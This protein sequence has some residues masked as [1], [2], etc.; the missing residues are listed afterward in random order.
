M[1]DWLLLTL[2]VLE[3]VGLIALFAISRRNRRRREAGKPRPPRPVRI[4][5]AILLLS[6]V[7]GFPVLTVYA[8]LNDH[9]KA[10]ARRDELRNQGT[11]AVGT[12]TRV[13][14]TGTMINQQPEVRVSVQVEPENGIPFRSHSTW[15]FSI[16]D[17]QRY[18]QGA[19]VRVM[20]DPEDTSFVAIVGLAE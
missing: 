2:M 13:S 11:P 6:V 8:F 9:L 1:A 16:A 17:T 19:R 5:T 18:E 10:E 3:L 4:A 15:V 20:Y 14:E 7:V 12:I